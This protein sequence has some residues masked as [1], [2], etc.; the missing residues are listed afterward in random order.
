[1]G[2]VKLVRWVG[3]V[4]GCSWLLLLFIAMPLKYAFGQPMAVRVVGMAHGV[5]FCLFVA[6]LL[7]AHLSQG[8]TMLKSAGLFLAALLPFGFIFVDRTLSDDAR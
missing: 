5:L 6:V 7:K 4:E 3:I 2:D 1:M 8:W